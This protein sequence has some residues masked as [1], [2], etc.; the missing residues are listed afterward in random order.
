LLQGLAQE[1][2]VRIGQ[3]SAQSGLAAEAVGLQRPAHGIGME[4]EFGGNSADLPLLGVKQI[5]DASDLFIGDHA[6]PREK[7]SPSAPGD[8]RSDRRPSRGRSL[9]RLKSQDRAPEWPPPAQARGALSDSHR[10]KPAR[11]IDL[12]RELLSVDD[13]RVGAGDGRD[14]LPGRGFVHSGGWP[15]GVEGGGI[16]HDIGG[17]NTADLDHN[18]GRDRTLRRREESDTHVGERLWNKARA[19]VSRGSAGQPAPIMEG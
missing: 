11:K 18:G 17:C 13:I 6:A 9:G 2:E 12:S 19:P 1:V 4:K 14:A 7:D 8:R 10:E 16:F 15:R 3:L 5:A